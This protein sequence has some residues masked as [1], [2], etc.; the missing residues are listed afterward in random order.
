MKKISAVVLLAC[1]LVFVLSSFAAAEDVSQE[2]FYREYIGKKIARC[3]QKAEMLSKCQTANLQEYS[4]RAREQSA[5]YRNNADNLVQMMV[6]G[7]V[8]QKNYKIDYLLIKAYADP[9]SMVALS[10]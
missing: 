9:A 3:E 7:N 5:F 4:A 10:Q 6:E 8:P 1:G 2:T